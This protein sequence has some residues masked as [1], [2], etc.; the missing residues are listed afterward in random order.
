MGRRASDVRAEYQDDSA[1]EVE[2]QFLETEKV[3][4]FGWATGPQWCG[5]TTG[6]GF[7][8]CLAPKPG[9]GSQTWWGNLVGEQLGGAKGK[10]AWIQ[11]TPWR[12]SAIA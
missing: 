7:N 3:P 9:A 1:Q 5:I 2:I 4:W 12:F 6:F 8:G 11:G 10:R